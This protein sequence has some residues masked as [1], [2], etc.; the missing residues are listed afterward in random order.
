[1]GRVPDAV[2]LL[3]GTLAD[4]ERVLAAGDPLTKA[5]RESLDAVTQA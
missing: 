5:V 2:K 3:S 1:M 4:C